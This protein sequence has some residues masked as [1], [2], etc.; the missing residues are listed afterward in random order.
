[1]EQSVFVM[2]CLKVTVHLSGADSHVPDPQETPCCDG[3]GLGARVPTRFCPPHMKSPDSESVCPLL[4]S[5]SARSVLDWFGLEKPW[6]TKRA[7]S[8]FPSSTPFSKWTLT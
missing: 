6:Q 2:Y 7:V 3:R 5:L 4:L 1:M 8:P